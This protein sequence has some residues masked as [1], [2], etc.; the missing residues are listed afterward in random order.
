MEA[1]GLNLKGK[2]DFLTEVQKRF[3]VKVVIENKETEIFSQNLVPFHAA[4]L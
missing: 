2:E 3:G 4:E 1:P